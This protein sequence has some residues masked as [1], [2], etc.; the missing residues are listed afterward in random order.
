[1]QTMTSCHAHNLRHGLRAGALETPKP[2]G[3]RVS[4]LPTDPMRKL[5]GED[6]H[7]THWYATAEE[8]DAALREMSRKH[9]YSRPGDKPALQ[10]EPLD[11]STQNVRP[12]N[13]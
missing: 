13:K 7:R 1:M 5:L 10:F 4:L 12:R 3:L 8:R 6:W 2:Y 11:V 9:E